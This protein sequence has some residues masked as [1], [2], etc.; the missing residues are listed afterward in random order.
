MNLRAVGI[1]GGALFLLAAG[2]CASPSSS[3]SSLYLAGYRYAPQPAMVAILNKEQQPVVNVL[4]SVAGIRPATGATPASV[5]VRMRFENKGSVAATFDPHSMV[6][7]SGSLQSFGPPQ[8]ASPQPLQL[9]PGQTATLAT[10]F[11]LLPGADPRTLGLDSMRLQWQV[12]IENN[13]IQ[14]T[15]YFER[16]APGYYGER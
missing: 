5:E 6:L 12:A 16:G 14:Q 13:P 8:V 4:V 11:P 1:I 3:P 10:F 9:A 15:A 7:V 2:G